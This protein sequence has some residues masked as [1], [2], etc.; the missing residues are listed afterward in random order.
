MDLWLKIDKTNV[1]IRISIYYVCQFSG[2]T[3][4]F[5]FFDPNLPKNEFWGR[6][7]KNLYQIRNLHIQDDMCVNFQLKQT[8]L[9]FLAQICP[10]RKLGFEIQKTNIGIRISI[11]EIPCV[12]IF[13]QN[14]QLWIFGPKFAS[15][16]GIRI[17]EILRVPFFR[18]YVYL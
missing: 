8:T 5:D 16:F 10:K 4:N 3:N 14:R 15:G 18:Y 1:T 2:K 13:R 7:F 12:P 11:L 6:N 17:L 9:T